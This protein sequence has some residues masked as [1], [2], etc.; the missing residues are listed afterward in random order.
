MVFFKKLNQCIFI[1][2]SEVF[3]V[4]LHLPCTSTPVFLFS[5]LKWTALCT[6]SNTS[7]FCSNF[8]T[9]GTLVERIYALY[10]ETS[11]EHNVSP[12]GLAGLECDNSNWP[13]VSSCLLGEKCKILTTKLVIPRLWRKQETSFLK[14][15]A[16][17]QES[18]LVLLLL[19]ENLTY[20]LNTGLLSG[21]ILLF[22]NMPSQLQPFSSSKVG[23]TRKNA[24][25]KKMAV[26]TTFFK[27]YSQQTFASVSYQRAKTP[28]PIETIG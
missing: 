2:S 23:W 17:W 5:R 7:L 13:N 9:D 16:E 6:L 25:E 19:S 21:K 12:Q 18:L 10:V 4:K 22:R 1:S 27:N 15:I 3:Y 20:Q 11:W 14:K 28:L 8:L 24:Y 26:L